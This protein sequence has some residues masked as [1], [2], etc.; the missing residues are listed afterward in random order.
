MGR[1]CLVAATCG[2]KREEFF[3]VAFYS[4]SDGK[5]I[6]GH[7]DGVFAH[8][9]SQIR[10]MN[11]EVAVCDGRFFAG[12]KHPGER[13]ARNGAALCGKVIED[14]AHASARDGQW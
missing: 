2:G 13:D 7:V 12:P 4:A 3:D 9:I 11:A 14:G 1:Y 8:G 6:L 5:R 10:D